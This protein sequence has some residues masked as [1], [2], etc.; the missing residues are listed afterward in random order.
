MDDRRAGRWSWLKGPGSG[1]QPSRA[2]WWEDGGRNGGFG[3]KGLPG[4]TGTSHGLEIRDL[5]QVLAL[6]GFPWPLTLVIPGPWFPSS[7]QR[8]SIRCSAYLMC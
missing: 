8:D 6:A 7:L 5:G 1:P 4:P 2:A 3:D